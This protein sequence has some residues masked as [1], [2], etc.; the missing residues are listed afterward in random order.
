MRLYPQ[1][2]RYGLRIGISVFR[3]GRYHEGVVS[4]RDSGIRDGSIAV[5][6]DPVLV[7]AFQPISIADI[8]LNL[9]IQGSEIDVEKGVVMRNDHP[10]RQRYPV[11]VH[12]KAR[13]DQMFVLRLISEHVRIDMVDIV[14]STESDGP[15][16]QSGT[17]SFTER[18]G[19]YSVISG[20]IHDRPV[21]LRHFR[22]ACF[23][24]EPDIPPVVIDCRQDNVAAQAVSLADNFETDF[25]AFEIY[26][27][28][29]ASKSTEPGIPSP[30]GKDIDD[31]VVAER[32]D[33][34][35]Y[36][37]DRMENR[38]FRTVVRHEPDQT[39]D[40]GH[41]HPPVRHAVHITH[42]L[43]CFQ[44]IVREMRVDIQEIRAVRMLQHGESSA[45]CTH[46]YP[47]GMILSDGVDII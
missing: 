26:P 42:F 30:V 31:V 22:Y 6:G 29:P 27:V 28:Q 47:A 37:P 38:E 18:S 41:E 12:G 10:V 2:D 4:G 8:A 24:R 9:E 33:V 44:R 1:I 34:S 20:I 16:F 15:V 7:V 3:R 13:N 40:C 23:R 5:S 11:T 14:L 46:P 45:V 35:R 25:I 21:G 32:M 19:H 43:A 36:L 39:A 17:S